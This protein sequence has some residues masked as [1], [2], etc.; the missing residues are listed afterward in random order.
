M[1]KKHRV[2]IVDDHEMFRAGVKVLLRK[3]ENVEFVGEAANGADFLELEVQ[4]KYTALKEYEQLPWNVTWQV[5][6][7]PKTVKIAAGSESLLKFVRDQL[8]SLH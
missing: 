4:G 1:K 6:K 5:V 3:S 8:A 7:I 2:I